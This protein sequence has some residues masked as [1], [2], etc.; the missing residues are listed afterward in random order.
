MTHLQYISVYHMYSGMLAWNVSHWRPFCRVC[1]TNT[2]SPLPSRRPLFPTTT[3]LSVSLTSVLS[4]TQTPLPPPIRTSTVPHDDA[5]VS[6]S[7]VCRVCHTYAPSPLPSRRPLFPTTTPLS[8]SLTSVLSVTQ[9]P[10]PP[11]HPDVLCAPQ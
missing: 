4:V 8:V 11:S 9:T 3:P 7:D 10:R 1:H 6:E 5:P 2:P